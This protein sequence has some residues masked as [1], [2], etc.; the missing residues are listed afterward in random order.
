[1]VLFHG[2]KIVVGLIQLIGHERVGPVIGIHPALRSQRGLSVVSVEI[3]QGLKV[4]GP[5]NL[6]CRLAQSQTFSLICLGR[7]ACGGARLRSQFLAQ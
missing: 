6:F 7:R 1:M 5:R 3:Q 2:C 4:R